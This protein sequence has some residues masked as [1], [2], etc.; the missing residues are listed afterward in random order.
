MTGIARLAFGVAEAETGDLL[1]RCF[2]RDPD[3]SF[4]GHRDLLL[5]LFVWSR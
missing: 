3:P 2:Y 1:S 5:T 4:H